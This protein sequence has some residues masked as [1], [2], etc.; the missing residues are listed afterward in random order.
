MIPSYYE[1]LPIVLLEAMSHGLSC[2]ASDIPANRELGLS[3]DR[4]FRPGDVV[5]LVEK[6]RE[7]INRPLSKEERR[8]QIRMMAERYDWGRLTEETVEVYRAI[9][10]SRL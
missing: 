2:I 1:G 3:D 5:G 10:G 4:F 6:I 9:V 8:R 7:F